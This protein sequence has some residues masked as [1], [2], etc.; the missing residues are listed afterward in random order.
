VAQASWLERVPTPS[1]PA[2]VARWDLG[3]GESAVLA[4]AVSTPDAVS[5]LDDQAARRCASA[6]GV[7]VVGTAGIVLLAKARNLIPEVRPV[8]ERLA[9]AGMYLSKELLAELLRRAAE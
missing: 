8:F 5:V 1:I 4:W 6:L 3:A 7:P 2:S 9:D